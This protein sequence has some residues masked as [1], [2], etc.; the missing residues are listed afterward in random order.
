MREPVCF[1]T[2]AHL[3]DGVVV[4]LDGALDGGEEGGVDEEGRERRPGRP[5]QRLKDVCKAGKYDVT[6]QI[7]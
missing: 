5:H 4:C 7:G 6:L 2:A 3:H 1:G